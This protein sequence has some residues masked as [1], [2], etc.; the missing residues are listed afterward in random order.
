MKGILGN[1]LVWGLVALA[2]VAVVGWGGAPG[3]GAERGHKVHPAVSMYEQQNPGQ[4]VPVIVRARGEAASQLARS[5]AGAR[6]LPVVGGFAALVSTAEVE[7]LASDAAVEAVSLDAVMTTSGRPEPEAA[8]ELATVYPFAANAVPAWGQG[9]T[10]EGVTVALID[11]GLSM[12]DDFQGRIAG[13]FAFADTEPSAVDLNGHGTHLAGVIGGRAEGYV[14]IAPD[15]R[16]LSLKVANRQGAALASDVIEALQWAVDHR[17]ELGIRVVNISLTSTLAD[18]YGQDPLDAAVEQ[19]W[20]HGIVVVVAAGNYGSEAFA[21]D[22]A[23]ANDPFVITVGAFD[24][25]GTADAADD[26]PA[27]WSARGVT[28]DGHAKPDVMAPGTNVTATLAGRGS[29][30]ARSFPEA[31]VDG[32][33]LR[34]SG[35][36]TSAAVVSGVVALML[37]REP[38]QTPNQVKFRLTHAGGTGDG[39]EAPRVDAYG[40]AFSTV[41]GEANEGAVPSDLIDSLTGD[42]LY[43]NVLWSRVLWSRVLWSRVLWSSVL[44]SH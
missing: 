16:L 27:A 17:D 19:A 14:G 20:F 5:V 4:K 7:R 3:A 12:D 40:A 25:A 31:V 2:V 33:Y 10:G 22:H 26:R 6:P 1:R 18:T 23:P 35:T 29:Y 9:V 44:W 13:R 37:E 30:L 8:A 42:I 15:A 11:T 43:D 21:V 28:V 34:L 38:G 36:S 41:G 39:W 24:D 32:D